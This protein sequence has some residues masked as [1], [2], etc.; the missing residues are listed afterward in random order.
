MAT[1]MI[2]DEEYRDDCISCGVPFDN[3]DHPTCCDDGCVDDETG[4]WWS[5]NGECEKCCHRAYHHHATKIEKTKRDDLW[6][7]FMANDVC[8]LC[9]NKGL[10]REHQVTTPFKDEVVDVPEHF[11]ICPNGRTLKAVFSKK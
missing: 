8:G 4:K 3:K 5:K 6:M 2:R 10:I 11:C 9:G 7:E 1:K